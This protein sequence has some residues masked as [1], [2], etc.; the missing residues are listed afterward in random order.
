VGGNLKKMKLKY[1]MISLFVL[2][3]ILAIIIYKFCFYYPDIKIKVSNLYNEHSN[4]VCLNDDY[5]R[6]KDGNIYNLVTQESLYHTNDRFAFI[7]SFDSLIWMVDNSDKDNLKAIDSSGKA[8][9][10]YSIPDYT[11]DFFIN[12]N[13][14]FCMSSDGIEIY[15]LYNDGHKEQISVDY[16]F[17]FESENSYFKLYKYSCEYGECLYFDMES[18]NYND[19]YFAV[20]SNMQNMISSNGRVNLLHYQQ[21]RIIYTESTFRLK[22]LYEY[23]FVDGEEHCYNN[24]DIDDYAQGFFENTPYA[25]NDKYIISVAQRTTSR[26]ITRDGGP[27]AT[28]CE[29]SKHKNDR[30]YIISTDD[31]T[32]SFQHGTRTFERILYADGE[33]AITYYNGE[34]LTYSLD[35]WEVIDSQSADEIQVGGSY[36]FESCGDYVFVFDD[37][38]GELLNTIDVS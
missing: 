35:K 11:K 18:D 20:D 13:V 36:T 25:S 3:I 5:Y 30:L 8:V 22:T 10:S 14:I 31:C 27:T 37:N 12:N 17:V 28:S 23:S 29:M 26:S 32:K 2:I 6:L 21:D 16:S 19:S 7:K 4:I 34:Y 9:K 15:Q 24:L 1:I 33:K 38:S